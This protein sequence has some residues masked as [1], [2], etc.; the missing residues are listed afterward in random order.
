MKVV[1]T[2]LVC[3]FLCISIAQV[4]QA[5]ERDRENTLSFQDVVSGKK[6][7]EYKVLNLEIQEMGVLI[8]AAKEK[9]CFLPFDEMIDDNIVEEKCSA[10]GYVAVYEQ[11]VE[12]VKEFFSNA[13]NYSIECHLRDE[14]VVGYSFSGHTIIEGEPTLV[15]SKALAF[16]LSQYPEPERRRSPGRVKK[17]ALDTLE[18]LWKYLKPY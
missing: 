11:E 8:T 13:K 10:D 5:Q 6:S 7:K 2:I 17:F 3:F 4:S 1:K 12:K 15:L 18:L 14:N 9:T 16:D